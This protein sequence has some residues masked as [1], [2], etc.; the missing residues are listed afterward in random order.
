M[1]TIATS[2]LI[3]DQITII[4]LIS[5]IITTMIS[6]QIITISVTLAISIANK[7]IASQLLE[8]VTIIITSRIT[9]HNSTEGV[10]DASMVTIAVPS[11]SISLVDE[12]V[13]LVDARVVV[14]VHHRVLM[15]RILHQPHQPREPSELQQ[16]I[17]L[18]DG[19]GEDIDL[20]FYTMHLMEWI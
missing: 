3:T 12:W 14:A 8:V 18:N 2:A 9:P 5:R 20:Q 16:L 19:L 7:L 13:Q 4:T 11:L 6:S 10:V 17:K 15:R 1:T